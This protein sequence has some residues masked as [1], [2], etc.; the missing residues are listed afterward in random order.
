MA[1][2]VKSNEAKN[3]NLPGRISKELISSWNGS[4]NVSLRMVTIEAQKE[5]QEPRKAHYHPNSEEC[6]YVLDGEG[7]TITDKKKHHIHKGDA[8]FIPKGE[9]HYTVN[10]GKNK[11]SLMC[12][13]PSENVEIISEK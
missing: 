2:V 7:I 4:T 10:V 13:F 3:L 11:L 1:Y 12:F 8:I 5:K 6:I 9:K